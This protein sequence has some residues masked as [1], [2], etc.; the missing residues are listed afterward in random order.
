L[1]ANFPQPSEIVPEYRSRNPAVRWLF[2]KRLDVALRLGRLE[3]RLRVAD[4]G[5]GEGLFL[6]RLRDASP[7][8]VLVGIDHNP[9]AAALTIPGAAV[10]QGDLTS[11][12]T[13]APGSFDRIFCLDVLEHIEDL[14]GPLALIRGALAPQGLL[15][16]SAPS[17]NVFHKTCRFLIK[18][19]FSEVAGPASSPHYH[20]AATLRRDIA[21]AGFEILEDAALPLPGPLSLLRLTS[22]RKR[23]ERRED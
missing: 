2:H 23:G 6:K 20:R 14:T 8:L 13:L 9:N 12:Q 19:T 10:R 22:F 18:G 1:A 21:A 11:P 3:G 15:V 7:E 4:L 5:C 17:E 16:I